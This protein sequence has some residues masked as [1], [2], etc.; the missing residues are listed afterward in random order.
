MPNALTHYTFAK[1]VA[2]DEGDFLLAAYLGAQGPD[3]FF[4]FGADALVFHSHA[5]AISSLG[6]VTQ[7]EPMAPT[8]WAMMAYAQKSEHKE[9]LFAYIDGL[10]MHYVVDCAC[11]PYIF[12]HTGFTDRPE[13]PPEVHHH[14]NFSHMC[15]EVILDFI[16]AKRKGTYQR[17]DKVLALKDADLK[18]I[19]RMWYD[20]NETV[21]KIPYI[22]KNSFYRAV[23]DY[24]YAQ[25]LAWDKTGR[26]KAF[27]KKFLGKESFYYGMIYPQNLKGFEGI[28]FLNESH[29]VWKMPAGLERTE[30]FLDLLEV[31]KSRYRKL[32]AL[33]LEAKAGQNVSSALDSLSEGLNHEGI[34]PNSPKLYWK[35][36]WPEDFLVDYP[37][38]T[39]H[40]I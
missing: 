18:V 7:H 34:I 2:L 36:I 5:K 11:H 6:G 22:R 29:A 40:P 19:S 4:F 20:V 8:Y 32:H 30:S 17:V 10:L 26:K 31:A 28:D 9:L 14:Y 35:L 39:S 21:Q 15:F 24:R 25:K 27:A 38:Y 23:K 13:D 1:D 33:L 37:G 3:P 16:Y 12:Y